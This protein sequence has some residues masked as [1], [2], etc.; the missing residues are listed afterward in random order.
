MARTDN[1]YKE[2]RPRD[3]LAACRKAGRDPG[4]IR[5]PEA[6]MRAYTRVGVQIRSRKNSR[7]EDKS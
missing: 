4:T 7:L 1:L 6:Y 3:F 2:T 5:D